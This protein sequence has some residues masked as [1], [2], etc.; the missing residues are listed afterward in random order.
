VERAIDS[1]SDTDAF[2]VGF[3][4]DIG[5]AIF[6]GLE[7][8]HIDEVDDGAAVGDLREVDESVIVGRFF[9]DEFDVG[10]FEGGDEGVDFD[11]SG[12]VFFDEFF[13][14]VGKGDNGLNA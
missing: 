5:G 10:F 7:D 8:A 14:V 3:D 1:V 9:V 11:V 13:D 6:D 4:V 12:V 2:F